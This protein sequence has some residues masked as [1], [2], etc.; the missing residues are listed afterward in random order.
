MQIRAVVTIC[1]PFAESRHPNEPSGGAAR[2]TDRRSRDSQIPPF[3]PAPRQSENA[4]DDG[5]ITRL[6][7]GDRPWPTYMEPTLPKSSIPWT[8]PQTVPTA[9]TATEETTPSGRSAAT[10]P[11]SAAKATTTFTAAAA[12]T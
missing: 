11:S 10:T 2:P 1:G 5:D 3:G 7:P 9:F 8:A 12:P 6:Q 4:S